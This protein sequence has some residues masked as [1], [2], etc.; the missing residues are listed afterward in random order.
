MEL[1]VVLLPI[2]FA[3]VVNP[4]L[5]AALIYA[6][7]SPRPLLLSSA[8]LAG[9]TLTYFGAGIVLAIGLESASHRLANPEPV[10]YIIEALAGVALLGI[11]A[12]MATGKQAADRMDSGAVAGLG[13]LGAFVAGMVINLVGIPFAVPYFGAIAQILKA[14][15]SAAAALAHLGLYNALYA[16]PFCLVILARVA[17]GAAAAAPLQRVNDALGTLSAALV[18][19]LLIGIGAAML[20]DS[21][22][23]WRTGV[24]LFL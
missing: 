13:L 12:A 18:P 4:V 21:G 3:D 10:D 16:L 2:L 20:A 6:L 1:W 24:G 8:L 7:G 23:Y 22:W 15:L 11:G 19:V 9:H 14:D 17:F 5:L